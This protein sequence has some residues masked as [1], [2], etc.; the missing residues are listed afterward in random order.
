M[1]GESRGGSLEDYKSLLPHFS[2]RHTVSFV[3]SITCTWMRGRSN[4]A[5]LNQ[6]LISCY[7][8]NCRQRNSVPFSSKVPGGP[9]GQGSEVIGEFPPSRP[10]GASLQHLSDLTCLTFLWGHRIVLYQ[11]T[12]VSTPYQPAQPRFL[13][14]FVSQ[15]HFYKFWFNAVL[16]FLTGSALINTIC[17]KVYMV[18]GC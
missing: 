3:C 16:R 9:S 2:D 1:H 8:G 4:M 11:D 17:F 18:N 15:V 13:Y 7:E 10:K 12:P 6:R 5:V 14:F